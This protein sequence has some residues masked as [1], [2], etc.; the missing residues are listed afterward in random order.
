MHPSERQLAFVIGGLL[1]LFN[2][3][4]VPILSLTKVDRPVAAI[5]VVDAVAVAVVGLIWLAARLF[6]DEDQ[7]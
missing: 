2:V 4:G 1:V 5:L 7:Q 6:P 3:F